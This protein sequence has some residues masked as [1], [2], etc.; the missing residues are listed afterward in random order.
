MKVI[1]FEDNARGELLSHLGF[2]SSQIALAAEEY[3]R[4]KTA[5]FLPPTPTPAATASALMQAVKS[6]DTTTADELFDAP[7]VHSPQSQSVMTGLTN[8]TN[9]SNGTEYIEVSLSKLAVSS[10][11]PSTST[12][13]LTPSAVAATADMVAAALAGEGEALSSALVRSAVGCTCHPS[14]YSTY[15]CICVNS[16]WLA[17]SYADG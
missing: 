13:D 6:I 2:D 16:P 15:T 11:G 12:L 3:V 9:T 7:S 17:V 8:T 1:C 14:R 4:S 10:S 5:H